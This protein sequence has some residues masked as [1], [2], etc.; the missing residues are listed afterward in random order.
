MSFPAVANWV[1]INFSVDTIGQ[2]FFNYKFPLNKL[3]LITILILFPEIL[4]G[5]LINDTT[6]EFMKKFKKE[7]QRHLA[8]KRS[9]TSLSDD[10]T[11]EIYKL[12]Y[13]HKE[14]NRDYFKMTRNVFDFQAHWICHFPLGC[15]YPEPYEI[16]TN[17][18]YQSLWNLLVLN[19][20]LQTYLIGNQVNSR[21]LWILNWLNEKSFCFLFSSKK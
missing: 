18:I 15:Q 5:K 13:H 7:K 19:S 2:I 3:R 12:W 17:R 4:D 1:S 9:Q 8:S 11:S 21:W 20:I 14:I 10:I 16:S 6:R